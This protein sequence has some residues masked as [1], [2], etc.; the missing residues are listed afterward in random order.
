MKKILSFILSALILAGTVTAQVKTT[1]TYKMRSN[2]LSTDFTKWNFLDIDG[3]QSVSSDLSLKCSTDGA[4]VELRLTP[5]ITVSEE[6][7]V[8]KTLG[9][10]YYNGWVKFGADKNWMLKSGVWDSRAVGCVTSSDLMFEG[11]DFDVVKPGLL[12]SIT[13]NKLGVDVSGQ[14]SSSKLTAMLQ[15]CNK[16]FEIRTAA[17]NVGG[18]KTGIF[19]M[20]ENAVFCVDTFMLESGY[21]TGAG[22]ILADAKC[23]NHEYAGALFYEPNFIPKTTALIGGTVEY[24]DATLVT[25]KGSGMLGYGFDFRACVKPTS[26]LALTTMNNFTVNQLDVN[27]DAALQNGYAMENMF[28]VLYNINPD[29]PDWKLTF[30]VRHYTGEVTNYKPALLKKASSVNPDSVNWVSNFR[31]AP[32]VEYIF[33]PN[34][35]IDM[36]VAVN[37]LNCFNSTENSSIKCTMQVPVVFQV[38]L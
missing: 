3:Y 32:A 33:S 25:K 9:L 19:K 4:G 27:A 31:I 30:T 29:N 16:T 6:G 2:A 11:I 23:S 37:I 10:N 13:S 24:K 18:S 5:A 34:A 7:A 22:R 14:G 38:S 35:K 8:T 36:G 12:T 17:M 15:F 21:K 20:N 1:A 26:S 28:N